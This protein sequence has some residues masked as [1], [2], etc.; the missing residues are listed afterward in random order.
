MSHLHLPRVA[1]ETIAPFALG[2][3]AIALSVTSAASDES[4][5][6]RFEDL[7]A[8]VPVTVGTQSGEFV[9]DTGANEV[10]IDTVTANDLG[11]RATSVHEE[12]GAGRGSLPTGDGGGVS[13][14]VGSVPLK[15]D[16]AGVAP[17]NR[18]LRPYNGLDIKGVIGA[19]FFMEHVVEID[20]AT[21]KL[22]LH[23]PASFAYHG[24]GVRLPFQFVDGDPVVQGQLVLGDGARLPL[25][26]LID[27]GA[28]ADLLVAAPFVKDHQLLIRMGPTVIEPL[29]AG[30][31][32]ET[33]YAFARL[34]GLKVG[35]DL[36]GADLIAGLSVN[37]TLRGGDYDALLG[38]GFLQR[39]RVFVDYPHQTMILEP[40]E[41]MPATSF[42]RSGAFLV[43]SG[44]KLDNIV[45]HEVVAGSPAD[46]AGVRSGDVIE[47]VDGRDVRDLRIWD[48]RKALSAPGER[49]VTLTL[50]RNGRSLSVPVR[51]KDLI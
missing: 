6:F 16:S 20:F 42:D 32:G 46:E 2:L 15:V 43:A 40:R 31:G 21:R 51:L 39:Y 29:G 18:V 25:R 8:Y 5:P 28:K 41:P 22:V 44:E 30:V 17:I 24:S 47:A 3:C 1:C 27:L 34:A 10:M 38:A 13:L 14:S 37:G 26:L 36:A 50:R 45:V 48:T 4:I 12:R 9:L 33:R 11:M 19:P 49:I 7:R 23:D 35:N